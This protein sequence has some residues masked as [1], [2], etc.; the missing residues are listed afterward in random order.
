MIKDWLDT[1]IETNVIFHEDN[2]KVRALITI[3]W[4]NGIDI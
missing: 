3:Y 1:R 4:N 2:Y